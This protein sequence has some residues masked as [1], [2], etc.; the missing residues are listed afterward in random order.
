MPE[1]ISA[2]KTGYE[3][4]GT[5]LVMMPHDRL[6]FT[7]PGRPGL[8]VCPDRQAGDADSRGIGSQSAPVRCMEVWMR[9][10]PETK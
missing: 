10:G 7:A 5:V 6:P 2:A 9:L 3:A 1:L 8:A 4:Y